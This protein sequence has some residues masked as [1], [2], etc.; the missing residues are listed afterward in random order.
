M[1]DQEIIP[2]GCGFVWHSAGG[3]RVGGWHV[4]DYMGAYSTA[5]VW[6]NR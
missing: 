6:S 3:W 1:A 4:V 5:I 2:V